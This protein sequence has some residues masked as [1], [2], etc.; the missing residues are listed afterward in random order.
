MLRCDNEKLAATG[1]KEG[2]ATHLAK[3]KDNQQQPDGRGKRKRTENLGKQVENSQQRTDNERKT[4]GGKRK[5]TDNLSR[6]KLL[7]DRKGHRLD[8]MD[9]EEVFEDVWGDEDGVDFNVPPG[10]EC[11]RDSGGDDVEVD[12]PG[13]ISTDQA[14]GGSSSEGDVS[15]SSEAIGE[16]EK[17]SN[18]GSDMDGA[19]E[20][21]G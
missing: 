13:D 2:L 6:N 10:S 5:K 20:G 8:E 1:T 16:E 4:Y 21:H 7:G 9:S 17:D 3:E 15:D 14:T 19:M 11:S 18:D 12:S